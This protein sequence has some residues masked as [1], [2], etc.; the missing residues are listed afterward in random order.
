MAD[1]ETPRSGKDSDTPLLHTIA[2]WVC[3][4]FALACLAVGILRL[5]QSNVGDASLGLGAGLL[6]AFAA[7]IDRFESVKGLGIEAKTRKLEGTIAEAEKALRR[8]REL[9]ELSGT[10]VIALNM[11]S[12]RFIGPS[13]WDNYSFAQEMKA[14]LQSFGS[15]DAAVRKALEPW[16]RV[17]CADVLL[18]LARKFKEAMDAAIRP[19]NDEIT[20]HPIISP[21]R[22]ALTARVT[23]AHEYAERVEQVGYTNALVAP[24]D[25]LRLYDEA[26]EIDQAARVRLR[27]YAE[28]F[29]P[30]LIGIREL[31]VPDARRTF[32]EIDRLH[33]RIVA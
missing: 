19:A 23:A 6:L 24:A 4:A 9:A 3:V 12:E 14:L 28:R 10:A 25:F 2:N 31:K 15:S 21:E 16:V 1:E 8:L 18:G 29:M 27:A 5:W 20:T 13:S 11:R 17:A 33:G 26:P 32:D 22:A 30:V 7:T